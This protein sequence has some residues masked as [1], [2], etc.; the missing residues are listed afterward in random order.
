[1]SHRKLSVVALCI[2]LCSATL[3]VGQSWPVQAQPTNFGYAVIG[4][5]NASTFGGIFASNFTSPAN[6]GEITE[7]QAYLATG[8]TQAKVVIYADNNG[9]PV[10][11]LAESALV[12]V[13]GTSGKWVTFPVS[14]VGSPNAVYWLGIV[15]ENAATYYYSTS[16]AEQA[17]YQAPLSDTLN[18]FPSGSNVTKGI[19]LSIVATYTPTA[20]P[21]TDQTPT[22]ASHLIWVVI[23]G[24]IV[25]A[26]VGVL[27]VVRS[28]KKNKT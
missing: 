12:T 7:I 24:V 5:S 28:R 14:H 19:Q 13:E 23:A 27:M 11:L 2:L 21:P 10:G 25:A 18:P 16:A 20:N 8:G 1:M 22:L 9:Q 4:N 3:A 6:I 26:A 15:I 17:I